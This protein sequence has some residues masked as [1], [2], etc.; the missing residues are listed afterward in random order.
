MGRLPRVLGTVLAMVL[1]VLGPLLVS[2][3]CLS[4]APV[5]SGAPAEEPAVAV[6]IEH[7]EPIS[8]SADQTVR[9]VGTVKNTGRLAL[10]EVQ[11]HVWSDSTPITTQQGLDAARR[12]PADQPVG[13]RL[14]SPELGNVFTITDVG[15]QTSQSFPEGRTTLAPGQ[16]APFT[17]QATVAGEDSLGLERPGVHLV[18]VHVRGIPQGQENQTLGRARTFFVRVPEGGVVRHAP[19]TAVV[20]LTSRPSRVGERTFADDHLADELGGRLDDLLTLAEQPGT[21][22]LVDPALVD[23][24]EAMAAGYQ[25]RTAKGATPQASTATGTRLAK[26]FLARLEA[27]VAKGETWRLPA[28]NPDLALAAGSGHTEVVTD[29]AEAPPSGHLLA[30]RPLALAP[31]GGVM[32]AASLLAA[33]A[34]SPSLVLVSDTASTSGVQKLAADGRAD[35]VRVRTDLFTGGPAPAPS[36]TPDQVTA[37]LQAQQ[38]VAGQPVV[39]LVTTSEQARA[40]AAAAPWRS[41]TPISRLLS[42]ATKAPR[43][44]LTQPPAGVS[45]QS[46]MAALDAA[47][48]ELAARGE[49]TAARGEE[50]H[51]MGHQ[52]LGQAVSSDWDRHRGQALSWLGRVREEQTQVLS[53]APVRLHVVEDFVTSGPEQQVPVTI[54]NGLDEA[55]RAKVVFTSENPQRIQVRDSAVHSIGPGEQATVKMV[56]DAR[57]NGPVGVQAQLVT[58]QGTPVGPPRSLTVTATQAGRVG[59]LIII[60][61]GAVFLVGTAVRI[62]QVQRE[63]RESANVTATR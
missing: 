1:L 62:R 30:G 41:R 26:S 5:A 22:L 11:A 37:G 27:R 39:S 48:G 59:W 2:S 16:S 18:G 19:T 38:F 50:P 55:V 61:S 51:R 8:G 52:V 10:R 3:L 44:A 56:V 28:G 17:V 32:D 29:A 23:S 58:P 20:Q 34:L 53:G 7:L 54:S 25:V 40:E 43:L 4:V 46:W 31:A 6:R 47:A 24:V 49:L 12:S 15:S 63:R 45:D 36:S 35:V 9:I 42:S 13:A 21:A 33:R 57:A 14:L 60:S